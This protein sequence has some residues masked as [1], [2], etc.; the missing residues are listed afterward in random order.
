[1]IYLASPY[2]H[3]SRE[4][5]EL[6]FKLT[7]HYGAG[8]LRMHL[9]IIS[10]IVY[11]HQF[12]D[13]GTTAE[14]WTFLNNELMSMCDKLWVLQLDGWKESRGVAEEIKAFHLRGIEPEFK[15]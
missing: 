4:V 13:Q 5:M 8:C 1:M 3:P 9:L 2:S 15:G 7:R 11:C 12:A 10:P 6:R 14:S